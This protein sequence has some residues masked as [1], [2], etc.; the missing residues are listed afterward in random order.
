M[1]KFAYYLPQ[2]HTIPENDEWWGK[3]FTEWTNV[4]K[5]R[6]LFKGHKQ[7]VVPLNGNYYNLLDPETIKWQ[8]EMARQYKVDGF[9]FYHYYFRGRKLLEKPAE[10]LLAHPEIPMKYFFCWANHDWNRAWEGKKEV[11]VK[12][13]Y[14]GKEDWENHFQY[15][16][17]FFRDK[18]YEKKD[19]RPLF[20]IF[21]PEFPEK[22]SIIAYFNQRCI[23]NGFSGICAI[24]T[25]FAYRKKKMEETEK[26]SSP[27]TTFIH[28]R[29]PSASTEHHFRTPTGI[30]HGGWVLTQQFMNDHFHTNQIVKYNGDNLYRNM[31]EK[32][33]GGKRYVRSLFFEWD[34]TPRHGKRGYIITPPKKETFM[35]YMDKI[36]DDEYVFLNAWNEWAEGMMLEP[37]EHNG[38]KYLEW[39]RE[40][41]EKA[42][43]QK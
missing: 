23:D 5:A 2:F 41:T 17:P 14:G 8:A 6:P 31:L 30:I 26:Q 27:L 34:N 36:R 38:Y 10:L 15:L 33:P 29:E 43:R 1:K 21:K 24:E 39:I 13:E 7:P 42:N 19:N 40:W 4:R 18:R 9:I 37:T 25:A 11:L 22:N 3:G 32:S 12:Q 28:L 35:K 20:L 16:L